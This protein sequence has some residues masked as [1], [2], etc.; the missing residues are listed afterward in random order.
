MN[1]LVQSA[2]NIYK[3]MGNL[4]V[5]L[6]MHPASIESESKLTTKE[7]IMSIIDQANHNVSNYESGKSKPFTGQRMSVHTWKTVKDKDSIMFGIKRDSKFVSLPLIK[8]DE[9][10]T[11]L[12]LI[13]PHVIEMLH[14]VQDKIIKEKLESDNNVVSISND[15]INM[16]SI[17]EYLNDSNDSGRLTKE[18]VSTWFGETIEASLA[19]S[20]AEKLGASENP[21]KEQSDKIMAIVGEFKNKISGLAGGK[22]NYAP[23]VA[24][25]LQKAL[26]FAPENDSLA[27]R[28]NDRLQKMIEV[29]E[30]DLLDAL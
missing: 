11:N 10:K 27:I 20:L 4:S 7:S 24:M 2:G 22:T 8:E 17:I 3:P 9:V 25:Q 6:K 23:K 13:M 5:V 1:N 21:T 12:P 29:K 14:K 15:L 30:S 18:S 26:A 19:V 28:F 16:S